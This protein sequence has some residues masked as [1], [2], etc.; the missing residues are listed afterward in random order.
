MKLRARVL[1]ILTLPLALI[2][3]GLMLP[4]ALLSGGVQAQGALGSATASATP[5][6]PAAWTIVESTNVGTGGNDLNGLIAVSP[7]N[8]WAVGSYYAPSLHVAQTLI[9]HWDG[10]NWSVVPSP[11]VGSE[12]NVLQAVAAV[13]ATDIWAVGRAGAD[14]N[15]V[16]LTEHWDGISWSIVPSPNPGPHQNRLWAVAAVGP[17]DVWAV[18]DSGISLEPQLTLILHW[19]GSQWQPSASPNGPPPANGLSGIAVVSATDIWAVGLTC[20]IQGVDFTLTEHWD[21]TSWSIIP[22]QP[23]A[24]LDYDLYAVAALASDNVWAVG[25]QRIGGHSLIMHWDGAT[26]TQ[27]PSPSPSTVYNSLVAVT[28]LAPNDIW[29]AG[30]AIDSNGEARTLVVHWDGTAWTQMPSPSLGPFFNELAAIVAVGPQDVWA[31][32]YVSTF[33]PADRTLV[34]RYIGGCP[35]SPTA[36]AAPA[37]ATAPPATA[38]A[39]PA[40]V[41]VAPAT[42]T[43]TPC[44][45]SF[46]DV[47]PSDPFYPYIRCLAC[48][49]VLSGYSTSPPCVPGSAPCFQGGAG[50]T[51]GQVAK[52][53]A[54]TAGFTDPIPSSQQTFEDVP[55]SSPFWLYVERASLHGVISGYTT[56][57]PC[58]GSM[59]CFLPGNPVTRGQMAKI[60]TQAVG[61]SETPPSTQQTFADVPYGSPFWLYVE[62]AAWHGVISGY[63]ANPPCA[64]ATPCFLPTNPLTRGQ[65]AKI[66]AN[67]FYPNCQT[68]IR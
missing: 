26:W 66:V 40:T 13:S 30:S 12:E 60:D 18:G 23:P 47:A 24:A 15:T 8:L 22:S 48:R 17:N 21:G 34:E 29:A 57:P 53:I 7:T 55:P 10:T 54:N 61:Y 44:A 62:R 52:I 59:P 16:T 67:T 63:S 28:A 1:P 5:P 27:V 41:T 11:N 50:I 19:N 31:A 58:P 45:V 3:L 39:L 64:G 46:A 6:C 49:G 2:A 56:S 36:T 4:H 35:P 20:C 51:R 65:A 25:V 9:E 33:N 42:A 14:P 68:P 32:G 37:T 38:T 43:V